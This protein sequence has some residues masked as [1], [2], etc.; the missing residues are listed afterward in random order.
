MSNFD[1]DFDFNLVSNSNSDPDS[2]SDDSDS[3]LSLF[4]LF[5]VN[6]NKPVDNSYFP[7]S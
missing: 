3:R 1:S 5:C 7:F 2:D 6:L 4:S